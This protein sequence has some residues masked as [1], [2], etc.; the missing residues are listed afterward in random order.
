M[1]QDKIQKAMKFAGE[2]HCNQILPGTKANY[3]LH[4]SNVLMEVLVAYQELPDF[5]ID[6]A[7]QI[8]V[9]HD[10]I[11]DGDVTPDEMARLFG[12]DVTEG[13]IALTKNESLPSKPEQMQDSLD[14]INRQSREVGIVKLADRIT[15]LQQPP[16]SWTIEKKLYYIKEANQIA[17]AMVGKHAYLEN[18]IKEKIREYENYI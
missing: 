15:N 8:A 2:Q 13:V 1:L 3:L 11:E 17:N 18:R 10:V 14:R 16:S 12:E 5:N 6:L 4:I 7:A 9:L